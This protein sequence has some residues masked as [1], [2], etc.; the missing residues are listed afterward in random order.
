MNRL[1]KV[2]GVPQRMVPSF[3]VGD[4]VRVGYRILEQGKER[5]A[6]FEGMVIRVRGTSTSKTFTVR[7]VTYGEGVERVFPLDAK[8]IARVDVVRRPSRVKR[9]RLYYLR[10]AIGK[11]RIETGEAEATGKESGAAVQHAVAAAAKPAESESLQA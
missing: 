10:R 7:R 3:R 1:D 9:S 6:N 2:P 8:M 11:S 5:I 4:E